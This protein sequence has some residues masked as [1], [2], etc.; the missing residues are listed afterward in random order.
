MYKIFECILHSILVEIDSKW[1]SKFRFI[2]SAMIILVNASTAKNPFE[3]I[4]RQE[5]II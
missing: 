2:E 1:V 5:V 4:F 3:L